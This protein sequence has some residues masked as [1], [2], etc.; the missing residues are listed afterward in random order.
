M[1]NRIES[2][3]RKSASDDSRPRDE[4]NNAKKVQTFV[5][6]TKQLSP[7]TPRRN[8]ISANYT[9]I[10][11]SSEENKKLTKH[12]SDPWSSSR[13]SVEEKK[14]PTKASRLSAQLFKKKEPSIVEHFQTKITSLP[15]SKKSCQDRI[16]ERLKTLTTESFK[17]TINPDP[18][19]LISLLTDEWMVHVCFDVRLRQA[20]N[21]LNTERALAEEQGWLSPLF[22]LTRL[23][24]LISFY[25]KCSTK[26][27]QE[28]VDAILGT[29]EMIPFLRK[30]QNA[31]FSKKWTEKIASLT[32][33]HL[34]S[35]CTELLQTF[36]LPQV[37]LKACSNNFLR[38]LERTAKIQYYNSPAK[39]PLPETIVKLCI[40]ENGL[41][42]LSIPRHF[43]LAKVVIDK[44]G[45]TQALQAVLDAKTPEE[46]LTHY[47]ELPDL[48]KTVTHHIIGGRPV[49]QEVSD[50]EKPE[51]IK[52]WTTS[53]TKLFKIQHALS[54]L[55]KLSVQLPLDFDYAS[56]TPLY[57]IELKQII[58]SF[59]A[60]AKNTFAHQKEIIIINNVDLT[61]PDLEALHKRLNN[62]KKSTSLKEVGALYFATWLIHQIEST[63]LQ[64]QISEQDVFDTLQTAECFLSENEKSNLKEFISESLSSFR[65]S[66]SQPTDITWNDQLRN[67]LLSN[68]ASIKISERCRAFLKKDLDQGSSSVTAEPLPDQKSTLSSRVPSLTSRIERGMTYAYLAET[69]HS[70]SLFLTFS[71]SC[72]AHGYTEI[73]KKFNGLANTLHEALKIKYAP[74]ANPTLYNATINTQTG[75]FEIIHKKKCQISKKLPGSTDETPF[76]ELPLVF[77]VKGTLKDYHYSGHISTDYV[78]MVREMNDHELD[79][80]AKELV[81]KLSIQS[82]EKN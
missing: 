59:R 67:H 26:K 52:N 41:G 69:F 35:T 16:L 30:W 49:M 14:V 82:K 63:I 2:E 37:D 73:N 76:T 64:R 42:L 29:K 61:L 3:Y 56:K 81:D 4:D 11:F 54:P 68:L 9:A 24:D 36:T 58:A 8:A 62:G 79:S 70:Y 55:E 60:F 33:T 65:F 45:L 78:H 32:L 46:L 38:E 43:E 19:K 15:V 44:Y 22:G 28:T 50:Y 75:E 77:T 1:A 12:G 7:K 18:N 51:K 21:L 47:S 71:T 6:E 20:S 23:D 17:T 53:V 40:D 27:Q 80:F 34:E 66:G 57:L 10:P 72:F 13:R 39:I 5:Q 25:D 74:H 31:E 48:L